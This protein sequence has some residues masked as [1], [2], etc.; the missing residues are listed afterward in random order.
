MDGNTV[1]IIVVVVLALL[2]LAGMIL[3]RQRGDVNFKLFGIEF[4]FRGENPAPKQ[5]DAPAPAHNAPAGEAGGV[6]IEEAKAGG[7]ILAEASDGGGVQ[8]KKVEAGDDIIASASKS[9]TDPKA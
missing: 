7:G 3:Y 5:P 4:G 6:K 8:M 9:D 1:L 2:A